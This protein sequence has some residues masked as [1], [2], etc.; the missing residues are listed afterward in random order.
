MAK[1][2]SDDTKALARSLFIKRATVPDISRETGVPRRTLYDWI[3][4]D[5]WHNLV[6]HDDIEDAY[7]RRILTIL[8]SPETL[9][10]AQLNEVEKL[11][12]LLAKHKKATTQTKVVQLPGEPNALQAEAHEL[13]GQLTLDAAEKVAS[14]QPKKGRKKRVKNDFRGIDRDTLLA[15]AKK[16]L[17]RYQW[18][19]LEKLLNDPGNETFRRRFYLKSRQ[20]GWTFYASLEAFVLA[21]IDG[22]NKAFLSA[23]KNQSRLFK[24]YILAFAMEW[25]EIEIKGGDEVTI[26]TD[27]GPVTF[28]FLS[29]NSSTSQGPSGDVYLDEVFW[30]RDFKKLNDLA[31]AIASHKHYRKTYFSTPS[32]KS[33]DAYQLWSGEEYQKVQEKRPHLPPF[34]MPNKKQLQKGCAANDE[35]YRKVITIHDA[36]AGGCDLFS[37]QQLEIE[38]VPETFRQLYECEFID[39]QNSAFVLNQLL[40]CAANDDRWHGF[41]PNQPRPYGNRPVAIGY[42]PSRTRDSAEVVVLA[43]PTTPGG[44]FTLLE[45]VTMIGENWQFQANTIKPLCEKYNV[46]FMGIDCTGPGNGVFEQVQA[47]YPAATP[48]HY[49]VDTK[50]RLVLKAQS[51]ITKNRIRWSCEFTDIPMAF[52]AIRRQSTGNG[53]TYVAARDKNI[54]HADVAWA[55]MHALQCEEL[56]SDTPNDRKTTVAI[57]EAA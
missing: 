11:E 38:N 12:G 31:G 29:T 10:P 14:A 18:V 15:L 30:I 17:F 32:T 7:N 45:R 47:F 3:E 36:M 1:R 8:N 16:K 51:I 48:I 25:F 26:Q 19:E 53:I 55:I 35:M 41:S 24:R 22:R 20:I 28:W 56:T 40:D 23:S 34:V 42:D 2:Y 27:H 50:T 13:Q 52:M 57:S 54:G 39:D 44:R 46:V 9:T 37:L 43:L 6:K 49:S 5:D 33:H 21:L 4:K